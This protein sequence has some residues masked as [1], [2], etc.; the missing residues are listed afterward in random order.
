MA[1]EVT[2][3]A[4]PPVARMLA[5]VGWLGLWLWRTVAKEHSDSPQARVLLE[6]LVFGESPRWHDGKLY[7]ADVKGKKVVAI[8]AASGVVAVV[9]EMPFPSSISGLGWL[10]DDR[11]L[12]VAM[13]ERQVVCDSQTYADLAAVSRVQCND[14]VVDSRGR[15]YVGNFGFD[16]AH[17]V[18]LRMRTTS[19]VMVDTDQS[20]H[21]VATDLF[22]PNGAVITPDG[23]T[24]IV[25]ETV[26]GRLAAFDVV[27]DSGFLRNRRVWAD[28]GVP[29]DGICLDAEG[30][31][32]VAVPQ[33]GLYHF[34]PG[35]VLRVAEGGAVLQ[36]I[37]FGQNGVRDGC[38]AC[39]LRGTHDT[40]TG[41]EK[42]TLFVL[43]AKSTDERTIL[44]NGPTN[45][46]R[47]LAFDVDVGPAKIPGD[48][49][50]CAGYC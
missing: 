35:G 4:L 22:F 1:E 12:V 41:D 37:G 32:W 44:R 26:A 19:L 38:M 17:D 24:L 27:P 48:D 5:P 45:N 50:Y 6:G 31:V 47:L 43:T 21:V 2:K 40:A 18:P 39:M 36:I 46:S 49:R 11:M 9:E 7:V 13:K 8:S 10:P 20:V 29:P 34:L 30:C 15:A 3:A 42:H 23:L 25:A 16:P 14:M 33:I 28:L